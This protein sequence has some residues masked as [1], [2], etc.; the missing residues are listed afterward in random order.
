M[1]DQRQNQ[2]DVERSDST[3][4]DQRKETYYRGGERQPKTSDVKRHNKG[5]TGKRQR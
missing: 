2:R 4:P 5:S 3:Q 1:K